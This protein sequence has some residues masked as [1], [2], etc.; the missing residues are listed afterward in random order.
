MLKYLI[1]TTLR[2]TG[3]EIRRLSSIQRPPFVAPDKMP[4]RLS[5]E[6]VEGAILYADREQALT[7]LPHGGAVAE[8]GV[9][10]GDFSAAMLARLTPH[11]FD[12]FDL[13]NVQ[14]RSE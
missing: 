9:A 6:H 4:C 11:R 8:I 5:Q 1:R 14:G 12:A 7:A 3:Y 13:F 2:A 10:A